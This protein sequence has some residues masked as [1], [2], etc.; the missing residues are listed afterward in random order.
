MKIAI[1]TDVF[2]EVPGGIPSSVEAQK[3]ELKKM[4][5]EVVIFCPAWKTDDDGHALINGHPELDVY[6]VP[7]FRWLKPGGAP[8]SKRPAVVKRWILQKFPD[9]DFDIVHSHYE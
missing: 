3:N 7:S 5:H 4:G 8:F 9:F 1:F 2:L 6:G